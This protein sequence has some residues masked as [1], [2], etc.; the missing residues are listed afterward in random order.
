MGKDRDSQDGGRWK[1]LRTH[2]GGGEFGRQLFLEPLLVSFLIQFFAKTWFSGE[3]D[4]VWWHLNPY[5]MVDSEKWEGLRSKAKY[6]GC[7]VPLASRNPLLP[8]PVTNS[9]S[10]LLVQL[11]ATRIKDSESC[12]S[13]AE[14]FWFLSCACMRVDQAHVSNLDIVSFINMYVCVA[15]SSMPVLLHVML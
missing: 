2:I 9:W 8:R 15:I 5:L 13:S 4:E 10:F 1:V 7:T 12:F 14:M 11:S 6:T 3:A